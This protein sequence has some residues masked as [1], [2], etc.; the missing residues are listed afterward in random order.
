MAR[1][2]DQGRELTL[3]LLEEGSLFGE[4][5]LME[6]NEPYDLM[7]ET[8]EDSLIVVLRRSDILAALQESLPATQALLRLSASGGRWPKIR[9][10]TWSFWKFPSGSPSCCCGCKTVKAAGAAATGR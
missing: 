5:G 9:S 3:Y 7:A 2:S 8:L 4:T 1:V 6:A 10:P